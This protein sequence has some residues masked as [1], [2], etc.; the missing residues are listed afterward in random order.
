MAAPQQLVCLTFDFDALSIWMARGETSPTPM[1]RGEFGLVGV[2]RILRL[3]VS[4]QI[5]ATFFVPGRT[6]ESFPSA[7]KDIFDAGHEIAH[8]GFDHISPAGLSAEAERDQLR[9]GNDLIGELTGAPTAG[10]RS[11]AWDLSA[12]SVDLLLEEGFVYDS[13]MMGHDCLPYAARSGDCVDPETGSFVV[14]HETSLVE[15]P[16]SWSMDDFPHFEYF[17]GGGLQPASGVL[18]NWL[19]DFEFFRRSNEWGVMT[20]TCHPF[21][22]GRGHRMLMLE[23][24]VQQ[25]K[26]A[27]AVFTTAGDAVHKWRERVTAG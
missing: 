21:V 23:S 18:E 26:S 13:S 14:G 20:F 5:K 4:E 12:S 24:F 7:C 8:H 17:R 25:L 3:L 2:E 16:I 27:G 6:L 9:R 22:I 19:G 15:L 11:P 10:Y 1:S